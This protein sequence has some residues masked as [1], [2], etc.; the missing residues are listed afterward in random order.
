MR[1]SKGSLRTD[2]SSSWA[3]AMGTLTTSRAATATS[4]SMQKYNAGRG[5]R[6]L[7][8]AGAADAVQELAELA[9]AFLD[10]VVAQEVRVDARH[11]GEANALPVEVLVDGIVGDLAARPDELARAW[12]LELET[13]H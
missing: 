9:A 11:G 6:R 13:H 10:A 4:R 1:G 8:R 5:V 12:E 7:V 2:Q 3:W